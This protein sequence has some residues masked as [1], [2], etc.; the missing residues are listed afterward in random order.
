MDSLSE[1]IDQA[2]IPKKKR[3]SRM[4]SQEEM[5]AQIKNENREGQKSQPNSQMWALCGAFDRDPGQFQ[6]VH[7]SAG[8][9][10][11]V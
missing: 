2:S 3:L 4:N 1:D 6:R 11:C 8:A 5:A 10:R 9:T 7:R